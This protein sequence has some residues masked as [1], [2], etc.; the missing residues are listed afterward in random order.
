M[1]PNEIVQAKTIKNKIATNKRFNSRFFFKLGAKKRKAMW[2][3]GG[4]FI[5]SHYWILQFYDL[6][7]S[8]QFK[9]WYF[10]IRPNF[11]YSIINMNMLNT[12]TQ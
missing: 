3:E 9:A 5:I 12:I 4:Y 2:I 6:F 11:S 10:T 1:I 7:T 8:D